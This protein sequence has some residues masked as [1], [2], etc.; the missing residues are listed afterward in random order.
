MACFLRDRGPESQSAGTLNI[1]GS[2]RVLDLFLII[3]AR[4]QDYRTSSLI[5]HNVYP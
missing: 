1:L 2:R 5:V 4:L 3:P